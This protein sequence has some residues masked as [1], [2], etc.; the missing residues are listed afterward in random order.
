[1][2]FQEIELPDG[3]VLEFPADMSDADIAAAVR[4]YQ[5]NGGSAVEA[6]ASTEPKPPQPAQP[7]TKSWGQTIKENLLGDDD[8]TTQNFG[9]KIG[10]A[11]NMAGESLTLGL[12]GDEASAA[13][14]SIM[15]GVDYEARRDHYRQQEALFRKDHPVASFTAEMAPVLIPGVGSMAVAK[16]ASGVARMGRGALASGTGGAIFG[17]MEGEGGLEDRMKNAAFTG[18]LGAGIGAAAPAV[19][20]AFQRLWEGH[21]RRKAVNQMIDVAPTADGLYRQ[22][23]GHYSKGAARGQI[24][25]PDEAIGLGVDMQQALHKKGALWSDGSL[26]ANDPATKQAIDALKPMAEHGLNGA[27]VKPVRKAVTRAAKQGDSH[28]GSALLEQF[29]DFVYSRAPEFQRGDELYARAKKVD[30][31]EDLIRGA[32]VEDTTNSLRAKFKTLGR[33]DIKGQLPGWTDDEIAAARRVVKGGPGE[34]T[35]RWVGSMAP[36]SA[37]ATILGTSVPGYIGYNLG[38]P[39]GAAAAGAA[40]YTLGKLGQTAASSAQRKNAD[41]AK[42]LAATGGKMPVPKLDALQRL[43]MDRLMAGT[44]PRAGMVLGQ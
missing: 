19:G 24:A 25:S 18:A 28:V 11:L 27:Q 13:V 7:E 5:G 38:G 37:W 23:H 26:V 8:P 6:Q 41:V 4:Q 36:K 43:L 40:T 16:G 3:T 12:I 31:I 9:E 22:A 33:K 32:E 44:A 20:G 39:V 1:M 29:D 15:P 42:A 34:R 35:A 14:E 30:Q 2:M 21:L 10:S 17:A